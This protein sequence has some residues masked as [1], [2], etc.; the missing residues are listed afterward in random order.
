MLR[1]PLQQLDAELPLPTYARQGDA[2][3]DLVARIDA[4]RRGEVPLSVPVALLAHYASG[5]DLPWLESQTFLAPFPRRAA[6]AARGVRF[7]RGR[8]P[9]GTG[10]A[11]EQHRTDESGNLTDGAIADK[12]PNRSAR[13]ERRLVIEATFTV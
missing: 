2:G 3:A 9:S 10:G 5:G 8:G 6:A 7:C 12:C 13:L 1:V 4:Y 11:G